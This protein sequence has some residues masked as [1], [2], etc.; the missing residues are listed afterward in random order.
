MFF[1]KKTS[2]VRSAHASFIG[3]KLLPRQKCFNRNANNTAYL[4]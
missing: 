3:I 2:P 4:F 1:A